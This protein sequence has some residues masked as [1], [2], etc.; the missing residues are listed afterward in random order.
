M[1]GRKAQGRMQM[2][3]NFVRIG[4]KMF[5]RQMRSLFGRRQMQLF[6]RASHRIGRQM[7]L[8]RFVNLPRGSV[9]NGRLF[10]PQLRQG[11]HLQQMRLCRSFGSRRQRRL[12]LQRKDLQR[13]QFVQHIVLRMRSVYGQCVV[14][15]SVSERPNPERNR[16]M[17]NGRSV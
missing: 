4:Q 3:G 11:R 17:R 8:L 6:W 12:L 10:V 1:F 7:R 15:V 13:G 14:S 2:H 5:R 16:R 9:Q